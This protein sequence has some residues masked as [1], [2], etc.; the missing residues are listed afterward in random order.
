VPSGFGWDY[1]NSWSGRVKGEYHNNYAALLDF[2]Y[3]F[4]L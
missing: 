3:R 1:G 2:S 4:N